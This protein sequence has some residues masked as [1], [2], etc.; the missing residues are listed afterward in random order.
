MIVDFHTHIFPPDVRERREEYVRA[1]PTFAEMY[2]DPKAKM[3]TAEDLLAAMNECGVGASVALGFAWEDPHHCTAH[4]DYLLE[5][6]ARSG[7]RIIPFCTVNMAGPRAEEEI[8]SC[9]SA[10]A[11]GLGELRPGNQGWELTGEAG[12][13]LAAAAA[14]LGLVLSFHVSEPVG[15]NYPGKSGG[16]LA[17]F[18]RFAAEHPEATAVGAHLA[19]GLPFYHAMPE[20]RTVLGRIFVDT[21]AQP[22]LYDTSVFGALIA[23]GSGQ[24]V[25]MGSDFPLISP[26]RQIEEISA[27]VP[28][29]AIRQQILGGNAQR[30]LGLSAQKER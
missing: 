10:G 5:A 12:G 8:E 3:A 23:T 21:A 13:R 27:G 2:G 7:G 28:D 25:L 11:R 17:A 22:L 26:A 14:Q 24:R 30:L 9:A 1:D 20:V 16:D 6:A 18:Y 4:N 19:G 15:H 29:P